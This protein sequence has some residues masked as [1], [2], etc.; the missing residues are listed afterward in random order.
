M[1]FTD[2]LTAQNVR[3]RSSPGNLRPCSLTLVDD[4]ITTGQARRTR[5]GRDPGDGY[6]VDH[7]WDVPL[8]DHA[9]TMTLAGKPSHTGP[10]TLRGARGTRRQCLAR[11]E[12]RHGAKESERSV[13]DSLS[14][15][16]FALTAEVQQI[17]SVIINIK[18]SQN[19]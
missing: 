9:H 16:R 6:G 10:H 1:E 15:R 13:D 7:S 8:L 3:K 17:M 2:S 5:C 12:S 18:E 14:E 19:K 11:D 4:L